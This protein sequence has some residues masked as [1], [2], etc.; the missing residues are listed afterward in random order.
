MDCLVAN[1]E[2]MRELKKSLTD[3]EISDL[4]ACAEECLNEKVNP[5][6]NKRHFISN[7]QKNDYVSLGTY[8]WPDPEKPDGTPYIRRDGYVNPLGRNDDYYDRGRIDKMFH[9]VFTLSN[10]YF[11]LGKEEYR[12][13]AK[14]HLDAWFINSET[15]MN[16]NLEFAQAI[17]GICNGRDIGIIDTY[18]FIELI[19]SA[20]LIDYDNLPA[21]KDWVEKYLNWLLTSENGVSEG[22]QGNNHGLWY[23]AQVLAFAAFTNNKKQIAE[24]SKRLVERIDNQVSENGSFPLELGRTRS[25]MYSIFAVRAICCGAVIV[26]KFDCN[27]WQKKLKCGTL[28]NCFDF[29]LPFALGDKEWEY[30]QIDE[31]DPTLQPMLFTFASNVYKK[32]EYKKAVKQL[33]EGLFDPTG[34]TLRYPL[35]SK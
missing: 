24:T 29:L 32:E 28:K 17:P 21:L 25:H 16:P 1:K 33:T 35:E 27:I 2:L 5:V 23:D 26:E 14:K 10:A 30:E 11:Y 8:W 34:I 18:Y 7:S 31:L 13:A 4:I 15:K 3:S 22:K 20:I 6:S 9:A 12:E 19:D